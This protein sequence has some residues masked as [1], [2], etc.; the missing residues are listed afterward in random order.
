MLDAVFAPKIE[1][2][3]DGWAG[4]LEQ[5]GLTPGQVVLFAFIVGL[6]ASFAVAMQ[7][8][9]LALILVLINR[10]LVGMAAAVG[11]KSSAVSPSF[12]YARKICDWIFYGAFVFLFTLGAI[13]HLMAGSFILFGYLSMAAAS[14][15]R[16]GNRQSFSL[17]GHAEIIIFML[18]VCVLPAAFSAIAAIFGLLCVVSATLTIRS[19]LKN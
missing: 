1:G 5:S 10:G 13:E 6:C 19:A 17:V 8:Y 11:R 18:A 15:F 12:F 9:P 16:E 7:I 14:V 3:F 2:I 4:R